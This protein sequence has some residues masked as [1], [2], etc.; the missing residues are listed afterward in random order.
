MAAEFGEINLLEE[1]L[2]ENSNMKTA[3]QSVTIYYGSYIPNAE[4]KE[5]IGLYLHSPNTPPWRGA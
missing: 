2:Q 4:V 5:C 3:M 1:N